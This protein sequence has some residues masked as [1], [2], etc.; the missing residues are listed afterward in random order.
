MCAIG[1]LAFAE[2]KERHKFV[3]CT[4]TYD[5]S[6]EPRSLSPGYLHPKSRTTT[7]GNPEIGLGLVEIYAH[8]L[9]KSVCGVD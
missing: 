3:L 7:Y 2:R 6:V 9:T 8:D 5:S 1:E 4:S